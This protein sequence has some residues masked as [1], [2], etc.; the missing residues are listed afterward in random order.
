[1]T[2]DNYVTNLISTASSRYFNVV[3]LHFYT[4][5]VMKCIYRSS[6]NTFSR[7]PKTKG[8]S[9]PPFNLIDKRGLNLK[10]QYFIDMLAIRIVTYTWFQTISPYLER[11]HT[12]NEDSGKSSHTP[13]DCNSPLW[14]N[15]VPWW[16][17]ISQFWVINCTHN[18]NSLKYKKSDFVNK[19]HLNKKR[20][21][22][23]FK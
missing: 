1:M 10:L 22:S 8:N 2:L 5:F 21:N 23:L 4:N 3:L 9:P 11:Y 20:Y 19:K 13:S 17:T 14:I 7:F 12:R 6:I 15:V 18:K 16:S